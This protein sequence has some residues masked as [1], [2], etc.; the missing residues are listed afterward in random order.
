M[1]QLPNANSLHF[2]FG[3][4]RLSTNGADSNVR[5]AAI[6]NG[7]VHLLQVL[8]CAVFLSDGDVHEERRWIIRRLC[9]LPAHY[10]VVMI[11]SKHPKAFWNHS[12]FSW[13]T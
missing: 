7:T 5:Y 10:I 12:V 11:I 9:L 1:Y 13:L 2:F 3:H 4:Q 6:T 8:M